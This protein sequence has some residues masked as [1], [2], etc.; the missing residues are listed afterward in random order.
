M[1]LKN[2]DMKNRNLYLLLTLLISFLASC[3]MTSTGLQVL[4]PADVTVPE[5]IQKVAIVNRTRPDKENKTLNVVEGI[6]SGEGIGADKEGAEE[7]I[8]GLRTALARTPRYEVVQPAGLNLKG[9]GT[10]VFPQPLSW[11]DVKKICEENKV[12]A[13]IALEAFD[14]DSR[15]HRDTRPVTVTNKDGS[16]SQVPEYLAS[17]E[18]RLTCGW[19]IYDAKNEKII[20]EHRSEAH[21]GFDSKGATPQAAES[22]LPWRRDAVKSTGQHAGD[23]YCYRIAP[24]WINV[25]RSYYK[26]GSDDLSDAAYFVRRGNWNDAIALWQKETGNADRKVAG[27]ACYNMALASEK[28]G[29]L[30]TA[31]DWANKSFKNGDKESPRYIS[32]LKGRIA[33]QERLKDQMK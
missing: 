7:C 9:T 19:R 26:K 4:K 25:S 29:K 33:D 30:E 6:F 31:L 15:M 12:D 21:R 32:I 16:K 28:E 5:H 18:M 3:K 22:G 27:R 11:P 13:V 14:S 10:S 1:R 17:L 2:H 23:L 20:D 8:F 24:M